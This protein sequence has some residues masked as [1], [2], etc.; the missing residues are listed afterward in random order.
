MSVSLLCLKTTTTHRFDSKVESHNS[1]RT[2]QNTLRFTWSNT[3]EFRLK[4]L[5]CIPKRLD[6]ALLRKNCSFQFV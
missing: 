4:L 5:S 2:E 6:H 3:N 1:K